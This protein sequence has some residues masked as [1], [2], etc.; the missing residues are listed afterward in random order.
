ML[1]PH[2]GGGPICL[3]WLAIPARA[4][5]R[6]S[7]R[8]N[9]RINAPQSTTP[10]GGRIL[11]PRTSRR[12]LT[13][14]RR[15]EGTWPKTRLRA[16]FQAGRQKR[17]TARDPPPAAKRRLSGCRGTAAGLLGLQTSLDASSFCRYQ[18]LHPG[19]HRFFTAQKRIR[20]RRYRHSRR[21]GRSGRGA[22]PLQI[23]EQARHRIGIGRGAQGARSL[24]RMAAK[25]LVWPKIHGHRARHFPDRSRS[26]DRTCVAQSVSCR[27]RAGSTRRSE[28]AVSCNR[29]QI[30]NRIPQNP[31]EIAISIS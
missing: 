8:H 18:R 15:K 12:I 31:A 14:K 30:I 3:S 5:P 16:P 10:V 20:P 4:S 9:D 7:R 25:D 28:V 24:W 1:S 21:F 26:T 17:K 23:Q 13:R 29:M 11:K 6:P 22:R 27:P 19:G 2:R